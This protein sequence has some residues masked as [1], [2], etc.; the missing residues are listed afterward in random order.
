[1]PTTKTAPTK[2]SGS[3][4]VRGPSTGT[5]PDRKEPTILSR[6]LYD[7]TDRAVNAL[8]AHPDLP[9]TIS[10]AVTED[11]LWVSPWIAGAPMQA[12]LAWHDVMRDTSREYEA[13]E[14]Y[15]KVTVRGFLED[16]PVIAQAVTF[17]EVTGRIDRLSEAALRQLA[18]REEPFERITDAEE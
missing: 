15:C 17:Q 3:G 12:I 5:A 9:E 13:G 10:L 11:A 4:R 8:R 7:F 14:G 1:M 6:S 18:K 16:V 2:S